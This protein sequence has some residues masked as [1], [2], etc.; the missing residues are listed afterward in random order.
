MGQWWK[1][2]RCGSGERLCLHVHLTLSH[3]G[4]RPAGYPLWP[5]GLLR[6]CL[7][8]QED[9]E[10]VL[11]GL[12]N[13][14][15]GLRRPI[16]LQMYDDNERFRPNRW[17]GWGFPSLCAACLKREQP[18]N[19]IIGKTYGVKGKHSDLHICVIINQRETPFNVNFVFMGRQKPK[20][21][22]F[23]KRRT[24]N[25]PSNQKST[26]GQM[27]V[28]RLINFCDRIW[29]WLTLNVNN[30]TFAC[31]FFFHRNSC[32]LVKQ[33]SA[34]SNNNSLITESGPTGE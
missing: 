20:T 13:I 24:N 14:Y 10:L 22:F 7:C 33:L 25:L 21:C 34:E 2:P 31:P 9:G 17:D 23:C 15:W 12:L 29:G 6:V 27:L 11:E 4:R 30:N 5:W 26:A 28:D 19:I 18:R 32:V 8:V 3:R 16:R 1:G